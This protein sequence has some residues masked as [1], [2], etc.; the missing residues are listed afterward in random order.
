VISLWINN[1]LILQYTNTSAFTSGNVMIGHTDQF[2]STGSPENFVIFDNVRVIRLDFE[3]R[4]IQLLPDNKVQIDFVSP[5]GGSASTL[6]LLSSP[7]LVPASWEPDLT[8]EITATADGFRAITST[9]S[10]D[11]FYRLTRP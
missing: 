8:A 2:S 4:S 10:G 7:V 11:R 5:L 3:I 9:G 1:N 6:R